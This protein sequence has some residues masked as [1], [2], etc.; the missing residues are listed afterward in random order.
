MKKVLCYL[1]WFLLLVVWCLHHIPSWYSGTNSLGKD[2]QAPLLHELLHRAT[3][4]RSVSSFL[5]VC[6]RHRKS[7]LFSASSSNNRSEI[8]ERYPGR[9]N[10]GLVYFL[11]PKHD[12][13]ATTSWHY[14][15]Q[16]NRKT[17]CYRSLSRS[18]GSI[19]KQASQPKYSFK[20][21][22]HIPT[23]R[24]LN[25]Y[26]KFHSPSP[27]ES[28]GTAHPRRKSQPTRLSCQR[29]CRIRLLEK[30]FCGPPWGCLLGLVSIL[31]LTRL[32]KVRI[33]KSTLDPSVGIDAPYVLP[34]GP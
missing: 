8:G 22:L 28:W 21:I 30:W 29:G 16:K 17:D 1:L 4:P 13:F 12:T 15:R 14:P 31:D 25:C 24:H 2:R 6:L 5:G 9:S 3:S 18:I 32:E 7:C 27:G 33:L 19:V 20:H 11:T 10:L 34:S 23:S 26:R